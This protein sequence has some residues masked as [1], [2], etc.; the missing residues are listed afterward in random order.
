MVIGFQLNYCKRHE[1]LASYLPFFPSCEFTCHTFSTTEL[2]VFKRTLF[3]KYRF[4]GTED[5][6]IFFASVT[7]L[8]EQGKL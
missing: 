4:V 7:D 3:E 2:V 5:N 8:A 6:I 1:H